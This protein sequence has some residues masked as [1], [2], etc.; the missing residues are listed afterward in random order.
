M[1]IQTLGVALLIVL[2]VFVILLLWL[3]TA[4]Q[5]RIDAMPKLMERDQEA[6]HRQMLT[7]MAEGLAQQG[8]R[9]STSQLDAAERL[10]IAVG[11]ELD[12][13][14]QSLTVLQAEQSQNL[15]ANREA[16]IRELA[17]LTLDLGKKQD[18]LKAEMLGSTLEKLAEQARLQQEALQLTMR[19]ATAAVK[20]TIE[21]RKSTRLNSSH[22]RLSRMP[23]SA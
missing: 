15:V 3:G 19:A 23:S 2:V 9:I 10:R 17:A 6:R 16:L 20:E 22:L 18:A 8:N 14:R 5:S 21:D 11:S 13:T 1:D 4:L 7:D 12:K